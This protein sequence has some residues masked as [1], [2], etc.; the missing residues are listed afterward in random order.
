MNFTPLSNYNLY[1]TLFGGQDFNWQEIND[2]Y[3]AFLQHAIIRVKPHDEGIFWQTYPEK[4][5]FDL[6]VNY[7]AAEEDFDSLKLNLESDSITSLALEKYP[8][9]RILKQDFEQTLIN[10]IISQ[11]KNLPAIRR[12]IKDLISK[13]GQEV[14]VE[15]GVYKLYPSI[16]RIA[17]LSIEELRSIGVGYRASYIQQTA[18]QLTQNKSTDRKEPTS[19]SVEHGVDSESKSEMTENGLKGLPS[20]KAR[21][22]LMTLPGVGPK[23]ADCTLVYGL[24]RRDIT[25]IDR[26]GFRIYE[27]LYQNKPTNNYEIVSRWFSE[28]FGKDTA[29]AGQVLFEYIRNA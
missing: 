16:E 9:L 22:L 15:G 6:V 29:Y 20:D 17:T 12:S 10:F 14:E 8:G 25:P 5:N 23:V 18:L 2:E 24:G 28:K 1:Q 3:W 21:E 26:W 11:N 4:D 19:I 27:Q 7:L 13:F